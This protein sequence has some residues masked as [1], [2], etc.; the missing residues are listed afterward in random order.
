[1]PYVYVRRDGRR[2]QR[3]PGGGRG[4]T[5]LP[6]PL[7]IDLENTLLG[8]AWTYERDGGGVSELR[9]GAATADGRDVTK[10]AGE[11]WRRSVARYLTP[12]VS[13]TYVFAG[14]QRSIR[15]PDGSRSLVSR[16]YR[17]SLASGDLARA[18]VRAQVFAAVRDRRSNLTIVG[19]TDSFFDPR[20]CGGTCAVRRIDRPSFD[21]VRTIDPPT[22]P[23]GD[24]GYE[25]QT[26]AGAFQ[27]LA[28]GTS[29]DTART[30]ARRPENGSLPFA[31]RG[32]RCRGEHV[33]AA[34]P[35][36]RVTCTRGTAEVTF[37]RS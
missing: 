35:Y 29:C 11:G 5:G 7:A 18:D 17:Y 16:M 13:E 6:G 8:M 4:S 12:A 25:P 31:E 15:R 9:V 33:E 30:I 23:C 3:Q 32:F 34:L 14:F 20:G 26:D 1:M 28:R 27:I 36:T 37:R 19:T 10:I 2:S 22:Q 21:F 24:V